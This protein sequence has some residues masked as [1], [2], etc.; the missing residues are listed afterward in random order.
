MGSDVREAVIS[1]A[2]FLHWLVTLDAWFKFST[3]AAFCL[4]G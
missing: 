3:A 1:Y 4:V 2:S